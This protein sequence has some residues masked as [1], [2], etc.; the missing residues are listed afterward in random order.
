M[1]LNSSKV[2]EALLHHAEQ[3]FDLEFQLK[4][5]AQLK[6]LAEKQKK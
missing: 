4:Q 2:N 5:R 1:I 6:Y 3:M